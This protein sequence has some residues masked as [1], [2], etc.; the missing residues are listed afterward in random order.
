MQ[1]YLLPGKSSTAKEVQQKPWKVLFAGLLPDTHLASFIIQLR[2]TCQGN[3]ATHSG[4]GPPS[5]INNQENLPK[6]CLEAN[7]ILVIAQLRP[8]SQVTLGNVKLTI[9]LGYTALPAINT[10]LSYFIPY[11]ISYKHLVYL[12]AQES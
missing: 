12:K 6:I 7:L 1:C 5:S 2:T 10:T 11:I 9:K 4:T 8:P 3:G